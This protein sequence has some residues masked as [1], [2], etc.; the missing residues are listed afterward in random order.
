[1]GALLTSRPRS[2]RRSSRLPSLVQRLEIARDGGAM[3]PHRARKGGER[4][5]LIALLLQMMEQQQASPGRRDLPL[6]IIAPPPAGPP[7]NGLKIL[8]HTYA[9]KRTNQAL[10]WG[11]D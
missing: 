10:P 11:Y 2:Q 7:T 5:P 8:L 3:H 1:M 6:L 4:A 9:F